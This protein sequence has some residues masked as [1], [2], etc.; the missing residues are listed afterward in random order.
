MRH[1]AKG[2]Q[3][4]RTCGPSSGPAAQHGGVACSS[5]RGSRPPSPRPRNCA[6]T[7]RSSSRSRAG[8][9]STPFGR[10]RPKIQDREILTKLF[11]TI[12]PR[13]ASSSWR[14]HPDPQARA[15]RRRRRGDG[16]HRAAR[17]VSWVRWPA[18]QHGQGTFGSPF[19][20]PGGNALRLVGGRPADGF[21]AR[22]DGGGRCRRGLDDPAALEALGADPNPAGCALDQDPDGL[23]VRKPAPLAAVVCVADMVAGYRPLAAHRADARHGIPPIQSQR[24]Q[25]Q[26]GKIAGPGRVREGGGFGLHR[27]CS[28][29]ESRF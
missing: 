22:H 14:L 21:A 4:S 16:A 9:T 7:P 2:R 15:P 26:T 12:G 24:F 10:W 23:Q 20:L 5:T 11:K 6:P 27:W 29:G 18:W 25:V 28:A 19:F 13:F 8:G 3:L 1:R 17:R